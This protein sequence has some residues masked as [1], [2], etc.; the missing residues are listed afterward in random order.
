MFGDEKNFKPNLLMLKKFGENRG[1][2][3]LKNTR[4]KQRKYL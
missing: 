4:L 2:K 3:F 1:Y